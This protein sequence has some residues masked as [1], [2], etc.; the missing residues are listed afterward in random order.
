VAAV[1][2]PDNE[3]A[4]LM[5]RVICAAFVLALAPSAL[6]APPAFA[7]DLDILRGTQTVGPARFTR[8]AGFYAGGQFN[9]SSTNADF[10]KASQPLISSSLQQTAVLSVAAPDQWR[11]LSRNSNSTTT[12]WGGFAGYNTQWQ[13]LILGIEGNYTHSPT[14]IVAGTTPLTRTTSAGGN[15][16]LIN[17]AATGEFGVT[18]FGS[19]RARA[20][21]VFGSFL[22]Y[23]FAGL[24]LGRGSY[25][26]ASDVSGQQ[27]SAGSVPCVVSTTCIDFDFPNS[28][29][30]TSALLYGISAGGGF[31]MAVTQNIFVRAEYEFVE[32]APVANITARISTARLGAGFKF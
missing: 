21:Y 9:Y 23:G 2:A 13:D 27:N 10:S 28:T 15:A 6:F 31:D 3:R 26:I 5:R 30:K 14:T 17:L 1:C 16:Y 19:L 8:W 4:R 12:G 32:F 20:G 18:D 11:V 29:G 22:P 25:N 7:D 24:A